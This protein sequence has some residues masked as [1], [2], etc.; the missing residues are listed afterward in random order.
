M[1]READWRTCCQYDHS[2]FLVVPLSVFLRGALLVD[3]DF[4][5]ALK[6]GI[7]LCKAINA[8]R[9]DR[10]LIE[11]I[12]TKPIALYERGNIEEYLKACTKL[13]V[14]SSDLFH[15]SDLHE[16]KY[17]PGVLQNILALGRLAESRNM[18]PESAPKMRR[19]RRA[20][21]SG[22]VLWADQEPPNP[23]LSAQPASEPGSRSSTPVS[24]SSTPVMTRQ[25]SSGSTGGA[26]Q[27]AAPPVSSG[28]SFRSAPLRTPDCASSRHCHNDADQCRAGAAA[29]GEEGRRAG[30]VQPV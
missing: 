10:P 27:A 4:W 16:K 25:S 28:A 7:V 15:I 13:G 8:L 14:A 24:R 29:A 3:M 18:L 23:S 17:L 12:Q 11:K 21:S 26:A 2:F 9:P 22:R 20:A 6:S 30:A 5:E 1:A 19:H